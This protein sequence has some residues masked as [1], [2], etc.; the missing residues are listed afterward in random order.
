MGRFWKCSAPTERFARCL[1]NGIW[2]RYSSVP[3][4]LLHQIQKV[5]EP[6]SWLKLAIVY[7]SIARGQEQPESDIDLAI[8][9]TSPLTVER[10][11]ELIEALS[12]NLGREVDLLDLFESTGTVLKEALSTGKIVINRTPDLF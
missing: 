5:L 3:H 10:K 12:S 4:L 1:R 11:L 2:V 7:G 8:A 9:S 6:F